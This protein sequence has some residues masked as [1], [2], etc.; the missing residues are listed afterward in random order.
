MKP[1]LLVV[2]LSIGTTA[3]V[4]TPYLEPEN[5]RFQDKNQ[6][7]IHAISLKRDNRL[8]NQDTEMN[9]K[10]PIDFY[11][12][13]FKSGSFYI[14]NYAKYFLKPETYNFK[15]KNCIDDSCLS[16]DID[17][18]VDKLVDPIFLLSVDDAGKPFISN[19]GK[20]L[21]CEQPQQSQDNETILNINL[22]ADTL[23]KFNGSSIGDLLPKGRQEVLDVASKISNQFVSVSSIKLTGHTDR[24]GSELYNQQLGQKRADTVRDLLT[25][26]SVNPGMITTSSAG[27]SQPVT[28]GCFDMKQRKQLEDCLQPDRRVTVEIKGISK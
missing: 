12:D 21:V 28:H 19:N 17:V 5:L 10:C 24:L 25:Q 9:Q 23:F 4:S 27:E 6:T 2:S 8:C 11:I 13:N 16:C 3:C 15:V 26:N 22:A 1:L 18:A 14:N 7:N 20:P